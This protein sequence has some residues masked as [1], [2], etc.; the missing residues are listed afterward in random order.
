MLQLI[1]WETFYLKAM[2]TQNG[3]KNMSIAYTIKQSNKVLSCHL[4]S[5]L[6]VNI[7]FHGYFH[8]RFKDAVL[9]KHLSYLGCLYRTKN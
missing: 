7:Y 4:M 6:F 1:F 5:L 8:L 2:Y 3:H 9:G